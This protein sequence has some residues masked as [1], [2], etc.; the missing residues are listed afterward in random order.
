M[1][2]SFFNRLVF[3]VVKAKLKA[4]WVCH[5]KCRNS[6]KT[7]F[8]SNDAILSLSFLFRKWLFLK[9]MMCVGNNF[10]NSYYFK[11]ASSYLLVKIEEK[12]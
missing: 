8:S 10:V 1:P 4:Q 2:A 3:V 12:H 9:A 5:A 6:F 11:Q 7:C